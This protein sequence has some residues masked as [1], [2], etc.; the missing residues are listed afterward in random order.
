MIEFV[1]LLALLIADEPNRA[2][3]NGGIQIFIESQRTASNGPG[4]ILATASGYYDGDSFPDK[5]VIYTYEHGP[6]RGD[7]VHG[8]FAVAFLTESFETTDILFIPE[9]EMVPDR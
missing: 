2:I 4:R 1:V 5:L 3:D 9:A 8:M 7:R 6:N